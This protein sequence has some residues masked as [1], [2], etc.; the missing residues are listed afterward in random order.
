V[1]V[2]EVEGTWKLRKPPTSHNDSLVVVRAG[3]GGIG[4]GGE[5]GGHME[6]EKTTNE[7]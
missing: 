6:A 5:G 7:S 4:G 3:S 1:V 2:V